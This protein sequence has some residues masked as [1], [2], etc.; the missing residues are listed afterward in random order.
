MIQEINVLFGHLLLIK[1]ISIKNIFQNFS[2]FGNHHPWMTSY[3]T[4]PS[5][6]INAE[7]MNVLLTR[8]ERNCTNEAATVLK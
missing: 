4:T 6:V 1:K 5:H 8:R 3:V 7:T 2:N